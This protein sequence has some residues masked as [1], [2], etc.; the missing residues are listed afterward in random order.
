MA[1]YMDYVK[2]LKELFLMSPSIASALVSTEVKNYNLTHR[3]N[4]CDVY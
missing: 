1:L 2:G 4:Y 3:S